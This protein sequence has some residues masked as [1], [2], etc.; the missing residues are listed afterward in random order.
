[1][2]YVTVFQDV[3]TPMECIEAT[4][5]DGKWSAKISLR[6]EFD[7]TGNRLPE[8]VIYPF[9][10][11]IHDIHAV[12]STLRRAQAAILNWYAM[13]WHP[14]DYLS[15]DDLVFSLWQAEP[16]PSQLNFSRNIICIGISIPKLTDLVFIDLPGTYTPLVMIAATRFSCRSN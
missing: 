9:G 7:D 4:E 2:Y 12:E 15:M 5:P 8:T 3:L 6:I 11:V 10:S 14:N 1:M 16:P 13:D